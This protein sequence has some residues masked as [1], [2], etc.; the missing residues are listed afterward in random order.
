MS[1]PDEFTVLRAL[2]P[3]G[4]GPAEPSYPSPS[5]VTIPVIAGGD[6]CVARGEDGMVQYKT[7]C[8]FWGDR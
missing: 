1:W 2:S 4:S 7:V 6:I 5:P 3:S 8:G